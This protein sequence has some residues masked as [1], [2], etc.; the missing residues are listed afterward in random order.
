MKSK[1]LL[2]TI[3]ALAAIAGTAV[4][5]DEA[6]ASQYRIQFQGTLARGAVRAEAATVTSNHST[7]PAGS[8]VAA[9]LRSSLDAKAVR[10]QAAEAVRLGRITRGEAGPT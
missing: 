3:G 10:A 2:V 7:E 5:A 6:D 8:R 9:P 4:H 1:M